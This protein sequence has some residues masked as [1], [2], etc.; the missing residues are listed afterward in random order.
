[1]DD[2]LDN[3]F[4]DDQNLINMD[5]LDAAIKESMRMYPPV[6]AIGREIPGTNIV[7]MLYFFQIMRD[8]DVWPEPLEFKP[9]RFLDSNVDS[10]KGLMREYPA[11]I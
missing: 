8:E 1:M 6:P 5:Y 7:A 2:A 9:S 4:L 10:F 3:L 11:N